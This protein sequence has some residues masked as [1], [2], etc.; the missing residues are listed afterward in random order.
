[1]EA[2]FKVVFNGHVFQ[3]C[4]D[5]VLYMRMLQLQVDKGLGKSFAGMLACVEGLHV[6][7]YSDEAEYELYRNKY[8]LPLAESPKN[9]AK[10]ALSPEHYR[11]QQTREAE[12]KALNKYFGEVFAQWFTLKPES[13]EYHLKEALKHKTLKNAKLLLDLAKPNIL[14]A[15]K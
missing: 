5:H 3:I 2:S 13:R 4:C 12:R 9:K 11:K 14:D 8:S 6:M 15:S 1:M 7:G 10:R